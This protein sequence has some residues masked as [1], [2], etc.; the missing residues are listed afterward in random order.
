MRELV[1][2]MSMS[3]DGFVAGGK[4]NSDWMFRGS[5]PD[6]AKW[7]Y[8]IID[9]ADV[10]LLGRNLFE[11]WVT[12]YPTSPIPVAG[13]VNAR[14]KVVFTR[15]AGYEP[16][17]GISQEADAATIA[18][19]TGAHVAGDVASEIQRLK[20]E[21][22]N[23]LLAQGGV[24]FARSLV[25]SGLVDEYRF[26]VLPVALGSGENIFAGMEGELDLDLVST[27]SFSG[28]A[29]GVVYRPRR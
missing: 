8:D 2:K 25:Q 1:L 28:G 19:Y 4:P 14:P 11:T 5:T 20:A 22:G 24:E 23:Y 18:T 26:A 27:T 12:F 21:N 7:V 3:I 16:G 13:P 17:A 29:V 9:G 10:H 15:R 6:S